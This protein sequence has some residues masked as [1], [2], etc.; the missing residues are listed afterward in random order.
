MS[1]GSWEYP[2]S[3]NEKVLR[4]ILLFQTELESN[5]IQESSASRT[6]GGVSGVQSLSERCFDDGRASCA[7]PAEDE[8]LAASAEAASNVLDL[9]I[10]SERGGR[11]ISEV[12]ELWPV[13]EPPVGEASLRPS[14]PSAPEAPAG[15]GREAFCWRCEALQ[16]R[17]AA[18]A[19]RAARLEA[20]LRRSEREELAARGQ[21]RK[22]QASL[23][24]RHEFHRDGV[25][26]PTPRCRSHAAATQSMLRWPPSSQRDSS[27]LMRWPPTCVPPRPPGD[28]PIDVETCCWAKRP[29]GTLPDVLLS[30]DLDIGI[31][32]LTLI[33]PPWQSSADYPEV[34]QAFL[35]KNR[36]R[37]VFADALV[38]YLEEVE[39][40]AASFPVVT[41]A[42]LVDVY[43]R[44]G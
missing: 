27:G 2:L 11:L 8:A 37:P 44:Y 6:V 23:A 21:A 20:A 13:V 43:S 10:S 29:A 22:L 7:H 4:L 31:R 5:F 26:W 15:D 35:E 9:A 34:V 40:G 12:S 32:S 3:R 41:R 24:L 30:V 38:R 18:S 36:V 19:A 28:S 14:R 17:L 25:E 33:V 16:E 42:R 39:A 1:G